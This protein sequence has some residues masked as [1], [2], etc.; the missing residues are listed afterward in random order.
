MKSILVTGSSSGI[1]AAICKHFSQIGWKVFGSVRNQN[2]G[3]KLIDICGEDFTPLIFDVTDT[4]AIKEAAN[5]VENLLGINGLDCLVN[6]AG[7]NISGP[8]EY[9]ESDE[10]RTVFEVNVMG[11]L[12]CSQIFLPMLKK[13]SSATIINISSMAGKIGLPM[14]GSYCGSKFALEGISESMRREL[15]IHNIKVVVIGPGAIESSI[16]D[17]FEKDEKEEQYKDTEYTSA[18]KK[19]DGTL[20][21]ARSIAIPAHR[22]AKKVENC[23]LYTSPS[24]RD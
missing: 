23:L 7:I 8:M 24:P 5:I 13:S 21:R 1:G 14:Q 4:N 17:K 15:Q 16:W 6:N 3:D 10:V 20:K 2:D 22:V 9:V 12:N 11:P 19:M 18:I